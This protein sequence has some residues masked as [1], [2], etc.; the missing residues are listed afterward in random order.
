M[1]FHL[2]GSRR[3]LRGIIAEVELEPWGGSIVAHERTLGP[4]MQ[5]R[6]RL[7]RAV[8]AN[9]SPVHA[10]FRGPSP[11]L[12]AFLTSATAG[13][14]ARGMTDESG[15]R[16]RLWASEDRDGVLARVLR[17][18]ELLIA[19]GHH[20]YAVALAYRQEMRSRHGSGPWD[21]M[22]MFVVDAATEDPPVLP[23]HRVLLKHPM[24]PEPPGERVRDLA[25]IL[26]SIRDDRPSYGTVRL[27]GDE[28]AHRV[29]P[30]DGAPPAVCALH[31]QVLD[32]APDSALAFLPDAAL[33]ERMVLDGTAAA[34]YLLPP[35]RVDRVWEVVAAN[36]R[37]PQKSTYFWPKPRTGM[38]L[39]SLMPS[40]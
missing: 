20:R 12:S 32:R 22:M 14:A 29:V 34:A 5:D 4:A 3:T 2:A 28:I 9:L 25:E 27:E 26:V 36:G 19:D 15:T 35:T 6:L 38:I 13:P 31:D 7:L 24:P 30:L 16:H 33:A 39:R 1:R 18:G 11:L 37:L 21:S 8:R 17:D 40:T 10:V 23:F